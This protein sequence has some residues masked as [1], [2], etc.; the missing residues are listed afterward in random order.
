[1]ISRRD[2]SIAVCRSL[3]VYFAWSAVLSLAFSLLNLFF[4]NLMILGL[5]LINSILNLSLAVGLW[6]GAGLF[7][8]WIRSWSRFRSK[9]GERMDGIQLETD[10]SVRSFHSYTFSL[11]ALILICTAVSGL[12]SQFT[13]SFYNFAQKTSFR[14]V[15]WIP[16]VIGWV[17]T[18]L[19]G[20]ALFVLNRKIV[21]MIYPSS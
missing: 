17:A 8:N 18:G 11:L 13:L 1:M 7:S 19:V 12:F 5:H 20:M 3:A 14:R 2:I 6:I 15:T 16:Y 21:R 9:N 4:S 10:T